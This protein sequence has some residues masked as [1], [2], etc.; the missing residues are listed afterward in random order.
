MIRNVLTVKAESSLARPPRHCRDERLVGMLTNYI[1]PKTF[2]V[3]LHRRPVLPSKITTG[4]IHLTSE[5]C[6]S[7]P[8]DQ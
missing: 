6:M 3:C 7:V 2:G 8:L 1:Q 4:S 5:T